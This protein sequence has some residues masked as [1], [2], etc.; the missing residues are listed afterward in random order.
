MTHHLPILFSTERL[1]FDNILV[2]M[3]DIRQPGDGLMSLAPADYQGIGSGST[4][5]LTL[6]ID[7]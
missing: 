2:T 4:A 5:T 6:K 7:E 1:K 3:L